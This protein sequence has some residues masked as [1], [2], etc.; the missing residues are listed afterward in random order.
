MSD[1]PAE[2]TEEPIEEAKTEEEQPELTKEQKDFNE[3][4]APCMEINIDYWNDNNDKQRKNDR[5]TS[6]A[7][8]G[9]W[10]NDDKKF[11]SHI[12]PNLEKVV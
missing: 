12:I 5:K 8:L 1:K 2:K 9:Y 4:I 3:L 7:R 6:I 11:N 10:L